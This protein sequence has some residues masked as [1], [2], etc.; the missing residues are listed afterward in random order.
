MTLHKTSNNDVN[1]KKYSYFCF[2]TLKSNILNEDI[3]IFFN[4]NA[5]STFQEQDRLCSLEK[6]YQALTGEEHFPK[7][8]SSVKEVSKHTTAGLSKLEK[9]YCNSG[10]FYSGELSKQESLHISETDLVYVDGPPHSP[11]P[12]SASSSSIIPS[13]ELCPVRLQEVN[14]REIRSERQPTKL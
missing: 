5:D 3:L 1:V 2:L 7:A 14:E 10:F 8:S 13:P 9:Y 11:C 12:S 4:I 6:R